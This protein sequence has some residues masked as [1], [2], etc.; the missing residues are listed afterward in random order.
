MFAADRRYADPEK[1]T[2]RLMEHAR[3]FEPVG[4]KNEIHDE[5]YRHEQTHADCG[6]ERCTQSRLIHSLI[7]V[8]RLY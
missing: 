5:P 6:A 8:R 7:Q 3:A 2:R 4:V 1:A